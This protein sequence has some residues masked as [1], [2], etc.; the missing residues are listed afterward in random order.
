MD[1]PAA[2]PKSDPK[3]LDVDPLITEYADSLKEKLGDK[4]T[5]DLDKYDVK[6]RIQ[7]MKHMVAVMPTANSRSPFPNPDPKGTKKK[8]KGLKIPGID[9]RKH[10]Q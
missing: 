5:A 6:E 8:E 7:I 9:W 1:P 4:Y 2:D 3:P 10:K